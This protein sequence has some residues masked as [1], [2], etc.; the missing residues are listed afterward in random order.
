VTEEELLDFK[1]QGKINRCRHIRL[2]D[3][4]SGLT[5]SHLHHPPI[6]FTGRM[7]FLPPNNSVKALKANECIFIADLN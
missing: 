1:V 4:P 6:F 5:G 7:P 3:T 2:G